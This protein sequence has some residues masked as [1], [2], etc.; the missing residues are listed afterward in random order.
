MGDP[1]RIL[2]DPVGY[3]RPWRQ[4]GDALPAVQRSLLNRHLIDHHQL[5]PPPPGWA[6]GAHSVLV[7]RLLQSWADL[8]AVAYLMACAQFRRGVL[9]RPDLM[10]LPPAVHAMLRLRHSDATA[11]GA[12]DAHCDAALLAWGGA[13]LQQLAPRLPAWLGTRMALLFHGLPAP[14]GALLPD[15]CFDF[16]CFR[17]ALIHA[18][19]DT[20]LRHRV[21]R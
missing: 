2:Y 5:A 10:S 18:A 7:Q 1:L 14:A 13:V 19:Y 12:L 21:C 20:Q 11:T 6:S 8:P 15:A 17:S 9:A 16:P 4:R 3:Y